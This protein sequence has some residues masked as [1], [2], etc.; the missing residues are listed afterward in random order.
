[1]DDD[2]GTLDRS[3]GQVAAPLR[4][5]IVALIPLFIA[6]PEI[7]RYSTAI[8][9]LAIV[10][11]LVGV[12]VPLR[13]ASAQLPPAVPPD[14]PPAE[15]PED[16]DF[17]INADCTTFSPFTQYAPEPEPGREG[18]PVDLTGSWVAVVTEDWRWRMMT[19][20][21][22]DYASIPISAEGARVA[23]TWDP[24]ETSCKHFGAAGLMRNPMRL[25]ISWH[26]DKTLRLETDHGMQTKLL[27]FDRSA[28]SSGPPSLQGDSFAQ[29]KESGLKVVTINLGPGYLRKNG[30]PYSGEYTELTEYFDRLHGVFGND[31]LIVTTVVRDPLYLT[32][33]FITST[34]FKKLSDDGSWNPVPC[35]PADSGTG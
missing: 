20:P 19:P 29:W 11:L 21:K 30:V 5:R 2:E 16:C 7:M 13:F 24:E 10:I 26:D 1:M 15:S 12:T 27:L 18:A 6:M 8:R 14:L 34:H 31:W 33:E 28:V 9:M 4:D 23:D 17:D 22:G 32:R 25:R 3:F 35:D